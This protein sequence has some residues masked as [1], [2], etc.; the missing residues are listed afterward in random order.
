MQ[1]RHQ[2]TLTQPLHCDL[3]TTEL[4]N[5]IELHA[6]GVGNCRLHR[7]DLDAKAKKEDAFERILKAQK[8]RKS[9]D[10]SLSH[11]Y[12]ARPIIFEP[13]A[14]G[15]SIT[16]AAAAKILTQCTRGGTHHVERP[17]RPHTRGT[18]HRRPKP[19]HGKMHVPRLPTQSK[20]H[21]TFMQPLQCVFAASCNK[22]ASLYAHGNT[23]ITKI[24][25]PFQCGPQPADSTHA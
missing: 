21:A 2:A 10:K 15:T 1:P 16:H 5:T 8:L 11:L 4:Q 12:T 6:H 25:Q 20:A 14:K 9:A 7:Q 17:Q 23:S 13:A 18:F 19:L 22:P 24:M 3:Q